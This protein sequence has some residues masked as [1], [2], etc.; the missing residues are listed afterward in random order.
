MRGHLQATDESQ[1]NVANRRGCKRGGLFSFLCLG[2]CA[3]KM[4]GAGG[5]NGQKKGGADA[6]RSGWMM[7]VDVRRCTCA[8]GDKHGISC[9]DKEGCTNLPSR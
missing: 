2:V 1:M 9:E 6:K 8:R 5:K 3:R 7:S 4:R